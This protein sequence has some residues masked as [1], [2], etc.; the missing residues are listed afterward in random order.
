M[1][2]SLLFVG[3][4]YKN[5]AFPRGLLIIVAPKFSACGELGDKSPLNDTGVPPVQGGGVTRNRE[6]SQNQFD[7]ELL[8]VKLKLLFFLF[9]M[10]LFHL[11]LAKL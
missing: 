9:W 2:F 7:L 10:P 5:S 3:F 6:H 8:R 1:H 4:Y 11:F